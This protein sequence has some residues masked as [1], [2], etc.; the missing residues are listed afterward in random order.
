MRMLFTMAYQ[1]HWLI[2]YY[3][4][5]SHYIGKVILLIF[6]LVIERQVKFG[7]IYDLSLAYVCNLLLSFTFSKGNQY[8]EL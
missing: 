6:T 2:V 1:D 3:L 8:F 7:F 5:S 4:N